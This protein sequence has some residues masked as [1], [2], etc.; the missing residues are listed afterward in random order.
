M[1]LKSSLR[2]K[3]ILI[4]GAL[5]FAS[6]SASALEENQIRLGVQAGH[7]GLLSD[8]GSR[9]NSAVGL[10]VV[11]NYLVSDEM[12][13]E[14]DYENSQH[15]DLRHSAFHG[16]VNYYFNSYDMAYYYFHLGAGFVSHDLSSL[17]TTDA[18]TSSQ[19]FALN[20]GLG[21]DFELGP[22]FATGI[23]AK[24]HNVFDTT[25]TV[26]GNEQ[27]KAVQ[28]YYTVMARF[29]FSFDLGRGK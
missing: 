23:V 25:V 21:V 10:G 12:A 17:G 9:H 13:F 22:N 19:A 7:V 16:G 6:L 14:L 2:V 5:I 28:S 29:L 3:T 20:A 26:N 15:N 1:N 18:S 24:Y 4:F 11:F 27:F 8:V